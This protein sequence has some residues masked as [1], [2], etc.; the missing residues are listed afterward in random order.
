[1][2]L[3][4]LLWGCICLLIQQYLAVE[5][6]CAQLVHNLKCLRIVLA[7]QDTGSYVQLQVCKQQ[8][9]LINRKA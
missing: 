2:L 7:Q 8:T 3:L 1:V 5:E 9:A 6:P 4:L